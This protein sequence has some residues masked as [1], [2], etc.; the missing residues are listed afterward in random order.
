MITLLKLGGSLITDKNTPHTIRAD[1]LHRLA[2]EIKAVWEPNHMP[3]IIGHG[4][5]SFGHVPAK[6]YGTRSGVHNASEWQGFAEV[7]SEATALNRMVTDILREEGLPIL[8]FVPM[9]NI[10]TN[11]GIVTRWDIFPIRQ[12]L[13]NRLI[14]LIFG[15]TIFDTTRGGTILS[16]EDL[17]LH[18][19]N[20][21]DKPNRIL[22]AGLE[23]GIWKDFPERTHLIR[24]IDANAPDSGNIL[25]SASTDVTGG[26][27]EKVR[28]MKKLVSEGKTESALIFSGEV[29]G[30]VSSA[31]LS[32]KSVGTLIRRTS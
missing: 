8:S 30:N 3:L 17:F 22:L 1:V 20:V 16:T 9:D 26:M 19:A 5:G 21:T 14:P 29:P 25:G 7:H 6:K 4:S 27:R 11:D 12:C 10:R 28:L 31:L 15:D 18:L 32:Q 2:K 24:E 13:S 23:Q